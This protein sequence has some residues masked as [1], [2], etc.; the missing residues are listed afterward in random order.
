MNLKISPRKIARTLIVIVI[1]LT[2]ASLAAQSADAVWNDKD[3]R[4]L[5]R[6]F[7]A[8][9]D[10]SVPTWYSSLTLLLCSALLGIIAAVKKRYGDRYT[11]HWGVLSIIFLLMSVD[12][13]AKIHEAVGN[14]SR[15]LAESAGFIPS[16]F[17]KYFWH[18]LWIVP[19]AVF[20]LVVLL[21]YLRFLAHLPRKTLLLFLAAGALFVGGAL[22]MEILEARQLNYFS[23]MTKSKSM[24]HDSYI[25]W[26]V[27]T[28][29]W[30]VQTSIEEALEMSSIVIF[31]YALISYIGSYVRDVTLQIRS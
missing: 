16:S 9:R 27:Q 30:P 10:T 31:I 5:L 12:E 29:W 15:P 4:K 23:E 8:G 1:F 26:A 13:V 7:S 19:G 22:G 18:Y 17:I 28:L 25:W 3:L 6:L 21:T 11:L 14:V 2:F 20:V 24:P